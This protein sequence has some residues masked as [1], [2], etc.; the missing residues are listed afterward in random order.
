MSDS[1]SA[2]NY[3]AAAGKLAEA[4][5]VYYAEKLDGNHLLLPSGLPQEFAPF[6]LKLAHQTAEHARK[7]EAERIRKAEL[8][9]DEWPPEMLRH[10]YDQR[11]LFD[12]KKFLKGDGTL[13][14]VPFSIDKFSFALL[15]SWKVAPLAPEDT[16]LTNLGAEL[17]YK[18][19]KDCKIKFAGMLDGASTRL[20]QDAVVHPALLGKL[21]G[22]GMVMLEFNF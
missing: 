9:V 16:R 4:G 1:P 2:N 17:G 19:F 3:G 11:K 18:P 22:N 14:R 5:W 6:I 7:Q 10:F 21:R 20:L 13:L 8:A 15:M 12:E